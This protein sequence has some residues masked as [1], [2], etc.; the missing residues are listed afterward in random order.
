M[1][2]LLKRFAHLFNCGRYDFRFNNIDCM[3]SGRVRFSFPNFL[4][5]FCSG[6]LCMVAD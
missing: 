2:V 1:S 5:V 6:A 3:V 4:D